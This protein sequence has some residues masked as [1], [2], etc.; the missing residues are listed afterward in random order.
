MDKKLPKRRFRKYVSGWEKKK[1][2]K[3]NGASANKQKGAL[4]KF[5]KRSKSESKNMATSSETAET[6]SVKKA[7]TAVVNVVRENSDATLTADQHLVVG[8]EQNVVDPLRNLDNPALRE[9]KIERSYID[10]LLQKDQSIL[11]NF[12]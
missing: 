7:E 1:K 4:Y 11:D 6:D 5:L 12:P 10:Y 9:E 2:K 3:A 8:H